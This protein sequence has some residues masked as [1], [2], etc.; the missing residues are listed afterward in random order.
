[1][2]SSALAQ[3]FWASDDARRARGRVLDRLGFGPEPRPSRTVWRWR[4]WHLLAY[5]PANRRHGAILVVPA[6][7]KAAY[8][9]DLTPGSSAVERLLSTGLQVYKVIWQRPEADDESLGLA[10]YAGAALGECLDTIRAETG[11]T[12][13]FLAGHSLGGTLAAIF[14]SLYPGRV[15]GL[16]EV[17]APMEFGAG[18]MEAALASGPHLSVIG[19]SFGNVPGTFLNLASA[20]ADPMS[21][22]AQPWLDL[23][24]SSASPQK[25]R[26]H[27]QV[28]RWTLDETPMARRLFEEVGETLYRENRFAERR[29]RVAG[30]LADPG[31]IDMPI[32]AVLDPRSRIVPPSSIEAYRSRTGSHDVEILEYFGDAGVM[33]QHVGVLVGK[34]AHETI[35]PR[36]ADWLQNAQRSTVNRAR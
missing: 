18:R 13:A 34:H 4:G 6:P 29:L 11:Q 25:N 30:R 28:R 33:L 5:Q 35:W 26:L 31:A 24:A 27:W 23:L 12:N 19:A 36:I 8:I 20:Y 21:F 17:E 22:G 15:R 14:A 1:M 3:A 2:A 32:L 16:I 7:I 10:Q 9:W